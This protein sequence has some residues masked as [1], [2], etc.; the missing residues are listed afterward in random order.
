LSLNVSFLSIKIIFDYWI[1]TTTWIRSRTR[2]KQ[3]VDLRLRMLFIKLISYKES[4]A[5]NLLVMNIFTTNN[6]V[7]SGLYL[8]IVAYVPMPWVRK[9]PT[10]FMIDLPRVIFYFQE[11]SANTCYLATCHLRNLHYRNRHVF[12]LASSLFPL[13]YAQINQ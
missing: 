1:S 8:I 7:K 4:F 12:F 6:L 13:S 2:R 10:C 3:I 5:T 9:S 11:R